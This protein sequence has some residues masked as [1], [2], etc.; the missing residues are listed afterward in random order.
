MARIQRGDMLKH[1]TRWLRI[2][3][4]NLFRV[5]QQLPGERLVSQASFA[6]PRVWLVRLAKGRKAETSAT[7]PE[8]V[9]TYAC[10]TRS[11]IWPPKSIVLD[12]GPKMDSDAIS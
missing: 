1:N 9:D 12:F 2:V 5:F 10:K 7:W 8:S 3:R 11:V 4:K 6:K